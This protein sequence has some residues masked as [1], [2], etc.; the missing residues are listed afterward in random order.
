MI[1]I[2]LYPLSGLA[3]PDIRHLAGMIRIE[4]RISFNKI[5]A[6]CHDIDVEGHALNKQHAY[7]VN[8][9]KRALMQQEVSYHIEHNLAIPSNS[10]W[11]CIISG[12]P[13]VSQFCRHILFSLEIKP[14]KNESVTKTQVSTLFLMFTSQLPFLVLERTQ[15]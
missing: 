10:A 11:S 9:A 12:Y 14:T 1:L 2:V 13:S 6:L 5:D 8:P 4:E 7:R 15:L 3:R